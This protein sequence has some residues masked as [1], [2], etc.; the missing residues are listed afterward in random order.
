MLLL[1]VFL[2]GH[3]YAQPAFTSA[4]MPNIGD[5][6]SITFLTHHQLTNDLDVE[7][8]NDY[9]W[10]FSSLP[11]STYPNFVDVDS[12]REKQHNMAEYFPDATIERY[13]SGVNGEKLGYYQYRNDTLL[14]YRYTSPS[15]AGW[16]PPIALM[17]FPLQFN[18]SSDIVSTFYYG[19][20]AT[21][22]RRAINTYDGF[23]TLKM[24]DN[25]SFNNVFRVKKV[26][27][28]TTFVTMSSITYISYIWYQ[29]GGK[30]PLLEIKY[31]GT[32]GNYF[33]FGSKA[34]GSQT[35]LNELVELK[36]MKLY[37]NPVQ[38]HLELEVLDA[39]KVL[40]T[41]LISPLG[42]V[43]KVFDYLPQSIDVSGLA[44]GYYYLQ[45]RSENEVN[46]MVFI[47]N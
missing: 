27:R 11:F 19:N 22:E 31:A 9:I 28:D 10:D 6:D 8:G 40:E 2:F 24:P 35:G 39:D 14:M 44:K 37:P 17:A 16:F 18:Q 3:S 32:P 23:G 42:Q 30:I 4:D 36:G 38:D 46:R 33:V 41:S 45:L 26:E 29:Q 47:K 21:G 5:S 20:L 15:S 7:T 43:I 13:T 1:A 12:Y 34:K 25:K